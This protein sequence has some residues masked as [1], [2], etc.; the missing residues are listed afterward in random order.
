MAW[1]QIISSTLT[2]VAA[3]VTAIGSVLVA[4]ARQVEAD[5]ARVQAEHIEL[6]TSARQFRISALR[7][8]A[9][10]ERLMIRAGIAVLDR[11]DELL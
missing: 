4:R 10:T 7:H 2:G 8:I 9:A 5:L 11:P 1:D 6:Q 3:I